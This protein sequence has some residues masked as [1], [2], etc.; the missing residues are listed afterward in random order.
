M[1][2]GILN[3]LDTRFRFLDY[4]RK[5]KMV[6]PSI[7][8]LVFTHR[9]V[10]GVDYKRAAIEDVWYR[11]YNGYQNDMRAILGCSTKACAEAVSEVNS[12]YA[13]TLKEAYN[14]VICK[15]IAEVIVCDYTY[16]ALS[17]S[18]N[19]VEPYCT[20]N[21][22]YVN[23]GMDCRYTIPDDAKTVLSNIGDIY[24]II[25]DVLDELKEDITKAEYELFVEVDPHNYRIYI[26]VASE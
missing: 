15:A 24:G 4:I 8:G 18:I 19:G 6:D 7:S 17:V 5:V 16:D 25:F 1:D 20:E 22:A 9:E 3:A 2:K 13:K 11:V 26:N 21:G 23:E 14:K 12:L 10:S